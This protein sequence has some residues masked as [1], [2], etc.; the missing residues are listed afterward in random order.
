MRKLPAAGGRFQGY[1]HG[2]FLYPHNLNEPWPGHYPTR[3]APELFDGRHLLLL[4]DVRYYH[5]H[6]AAGEVDP[7]PNSA[8]RGLV[9]DGG[10][11]RTIA[12]W[13]LISTP[14]RDHLPAFLVHDQLCQEAR[15]LANS[16]RA[17]TDPLQARL[18]LE[19]ACKLRL[20]A[21]RLIYPMMLDTNAR[22]WQAKGVY[23]AVRRGASW[24]GLG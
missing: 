23:R 1:A 13:G 22:R 12:G 6:N 20:F 18:L 2:V 7:V 17:S 11:I 14:F 21:D 4:G 9:S 10:T 24:A 16:A 5:V 3:P 15:R 8:R 19:E